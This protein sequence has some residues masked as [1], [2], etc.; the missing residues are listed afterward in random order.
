[1]L[2]PIKRASIYSPG[3]PQREGR[4]TPY[5]DTADARRKDQTLAQRLKE[6]V[7]TPDDKKQHSRGDWVPFGPHNELGIRTIQVMNE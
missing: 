4:S 3:H 5:K 7:S 6:T 2:S 1:R